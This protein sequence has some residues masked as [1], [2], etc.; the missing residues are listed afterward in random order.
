MIN[1]F[2][3][4]NYQPIGRV[5]KGTRTYSPPTH[6]GSRIAKY[7]K[8]V[9]CWYAREPGADRPLDKDTRRQALV[10]LINRAAGRRREQ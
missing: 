8:E 6:K 3:C 9:S 1:R 2:L 10:W 7:H 4:W 5:W